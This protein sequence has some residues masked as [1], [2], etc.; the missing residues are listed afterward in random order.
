MEEPKEKVSAPITTIEE[1]H[2]LSGQQ[3]PTGGQHSPQQTTK[4][5]VFFSFYISL[6]GL[7]FNFDLSE[8][9]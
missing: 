2:G 3:A 4:Q 1:S 5:M 8:F 6:V 7:V 9:R